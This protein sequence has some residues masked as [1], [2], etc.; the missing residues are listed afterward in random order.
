MGFMACN[1]KAD[2]KQLQLYMQVERSVC[3]LLLLARQQHYGTLTGLQLLMGLASGC[4][5]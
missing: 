2:P 1:S 5:G 3:V 4:S